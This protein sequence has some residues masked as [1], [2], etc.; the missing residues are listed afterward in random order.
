MEL[1]RD[2]VDSANPALK[3]LGILVTQH[4]GRKNVCKSMRGVIERRFGDLVFKTAIPLA[5]KIQESESL[6]KT[7]FQLDR[8]SNAAREFMDLGREVL[9]RMGLGALAEPEDMEEPVEVGAG[10]S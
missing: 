10:E 4:D 5:A 1:V 9:A 6:K 3:C 8:Q 2:V 7:I